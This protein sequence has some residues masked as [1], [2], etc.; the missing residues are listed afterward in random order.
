MVPKNVETVMNRRDLFK[1]IPAGLVASVVGIKSKPDTKEANVLKYIEDS[2]NNGDTIRAIKP[3][4]AE[5]K[6]GLIKGLSFY[7]KRR[8]TVIN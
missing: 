6:P 4:L 1:L 7:G 3:G 8:F 2:L 5:L